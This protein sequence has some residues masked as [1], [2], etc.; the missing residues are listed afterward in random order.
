MEEEDDC[1][2]LVLNYCDPLVAGCR[3]GA[4]HKTPRIHQW[5]EEEEEEEETAYKITLPA[6]NM[7]E[8][9]SV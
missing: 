3:F 4:D 7:E 6:I 2:V 1:A 9:I 8:E 5:K